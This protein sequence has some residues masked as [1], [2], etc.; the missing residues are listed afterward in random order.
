MRVHES[1]SLTLS[2]QMAVK[3]GCDSY[4]KIST[5]PQLASKSFIQLPRRIQKGLLRPFT[6]PFPT[7]KRLDLV[8]GTHVLPSGIKQHV[9]IQA[10]QI[11]TLSSGPKQS[12]EMLPKQHR[13]SCKHLMRTISRKSI[14]PALGQT[15]K[16]LKL[17]SLTHAQ[18]I[19][20]IFSVCHNP[21]NRISISNLTCTIF[22]RS[23]S[24]ISEWLSIDPGGKRLY[25]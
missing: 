17:P 24:V 3:L 13:S 18:N 21:L 2:A 10:K 19:F 5:L 7:S 4:S 1:N 23:S 11:S 6:R 15:S 12:P 14:N 20:N 8:L 25:H 9:S 16:F 22:L